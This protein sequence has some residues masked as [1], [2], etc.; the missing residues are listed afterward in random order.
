MYLIAYS[1]IR[2]LYAAAEFHLHRKEC[3]APFEM[4]GSVVIEEYIRL[5]EEFERCDMK[6]S[7]FAIDTGVEVND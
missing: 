4:E 2:K 3:Y 6:T 7:S 1:R 5:I